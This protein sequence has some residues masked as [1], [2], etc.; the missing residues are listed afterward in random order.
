MFF[1]RSMSAALDEF[2]E[3][4]SRAREPRT[5]GS[6][7]HAEGERAILVAEAGPRAEREHLLLMDRK[8]VD[9]REHLPHLLLVGEPPD[10]LVAEVGFGCRVEA[11]DRCDR[12]TAR[13]AAIP[14]E[15]QGDP[16]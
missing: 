6:D 15:V 3:V 10:D 16:E 11:R 8:L 9:H 2:P 12:P 4:R 14:D 13:A 7:R 1:S 5:D